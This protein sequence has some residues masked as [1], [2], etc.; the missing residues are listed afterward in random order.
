MKKLSTLFFLLIFSIPLLAQHTLLQIRKPEFQ[1]DIKKI[2]KSGNLMYAVGSR[3]TVRSFVAVSEDLGGSWHSTPSQPF[4][5]GDNLQSIFFRDEKNGWVGGSQGII[6]KTTD[7]GA[8]WQEQTDTLVYKGTIND[9]YFSDPDTGYICGSGSNNSAKLLKTTDGGRNWKEVTIPSITDL[10]FLAMSWENSSKGILVGNIKTVLITSDGGMNWHTATIGQ[11]LKTVYMYS[12]TRSASGNYFISGRFGRIFKSTDGG[13]TFSL[14]SYAG[15]DNLYSISFLNPLEGLACGAYGNIYR[16]ADGGSSWSQISNFTSDQLNSV[17]PLGNDKVAVMGS[18]GVLFF[19]DDRGLTW[20]TSTIS[21]RDFYS[22]VAQDSLNITVAGGSAYE[23]EIDVTHDGGVSWQRQP[24][25]AGGA[26]RSIF[27]VG[28]NLYTC[29]KGG[30]FY[31]S[32]NNGSAWDQLRPAGTYTNYKLFFNDENNGYIVNGSTTQK[33]DT[34]IIVG[35]IFK[36]S[37]KGNNWTKLAEFNGELRDIKM[38]SYTR[39][40]AAGGGGK[41]YETYDGINWSHGSLASPDVNLN[42]VYMLNELYGFACGQR[43]AIY[44]TTD[45]FKTIEL[46]TDTLALKGIQIN[47]ILAM[48]DSTVWAVAD[49]GLILSFVSENKMAVVDTGYYG[50]NLTSISKLNST[51]LALCGAN[52]SLYKLSFKPGIT[53]GVSPS[54]KIAESFELKQNYPNPFNPETVISYRLANDGYVRL[55]VFDVLGKEVARLEDGFKRAGNYSVRFNALEEG[56]GSG[57]Y[58]Y[59]LEAGKSVQTRKMLLIK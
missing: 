1:G 33:T 44:R 49:K 8:T 58:F 40:F 54:H 34:T 29:G 6:Y 9:I 37:D 7:G 56:L 28:N 30:S 51:S 18:A 31:H 19:S 47:D 12:I 24:L 4:R 32:S 39:G 2:V 14:L 53:D 38:L 22:A 3:L 5:A 27:A 15:S 55:R 42:S 25:R 23:G 11:G 50:E 46:L 17:L 10:S 36:T 59:R 43:G 52:G 16:T 21:S 45:G 26:L 41:I 13:E 35:Q 57:I 20:K 48:N